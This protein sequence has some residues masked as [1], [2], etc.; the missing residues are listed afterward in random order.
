MSLPWGNAQTHSVRT[1]HCWA[2][3]PGAA[4]GTSGASGPAQ[5]QSGV[6]PVQEA[7]LE[8]RKIK[9]TWMRFYYQGT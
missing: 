7:E 3:A 2:W 1:R 4:A 5:T 9:R 8:L 6:E